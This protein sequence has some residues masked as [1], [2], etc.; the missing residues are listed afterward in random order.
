MPRT[1]SRSSHLALTNCPASLLRDGNQRIIGALRVL[2]QRVCRGLM[3]SDYRSDVPSSPAMRRGWAIGALLALLGCKQ[4]FGGGN[5]LE[6]P[7]DDP[8]GTDGG[9]I[10]PPTGSVYVASDSI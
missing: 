4:P 8:A 9:T 6:P 2:T 5:S 1:P 3:P 10:V 7:I